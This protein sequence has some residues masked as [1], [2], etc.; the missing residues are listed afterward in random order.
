MCVDCVHI[1][2]HIYSLYFSVVVAMFF[3]FFNPLPMLRHAD[4]MALFQRFA[5]VRVSVTCI[6]ILV[7]V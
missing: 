4:K 7:C 3:R 6:S 1:S 2:S 5:V